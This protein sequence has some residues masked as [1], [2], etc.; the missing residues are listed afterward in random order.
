MAVFTAEFAG[1][2]GINPRLTRLIALENTFDEIT[3][4]GYLNRLTALGNPVLSTDFVFASYLDGYGTFNPSIDPSTGIITLIPT[5]AN[6]VI[7]ISPTDGMGSLQ[8]VS[9]DNAGDY[10]N[11]LTNAST[12]Q[13]T[14]W[15]LPDPG[16]ATANILLDKSSGTQTISA[17]NLAVSAG[18]FTASGAITSTA[19]AL[20]SGLAAGGFVGKTTL[21]PTTAAKGSVTWQAADNTGDTATIFTNAA[22]GQASTIS[23]PDPGA[24]AANFLLSKMTGTQH[25]TVGNLAIDAGALISGIATGGFVGKVQLFPTTASKGSLT[26]QATANSG[27]TATVF[28]T[29]ALGQATT[30]TVPDPV[31]AS[32]A[33]VVA[34]AALVSGNLVKASG[35]A[36]LVTDAGARI[37]SD[38][39]G[40]YGGGGTNNVFAA[41]GLTVAAKGAAVIRTSANSVSITKALPGTDTLDITFSA[42]PGAGTTVDYI[43]TTASQA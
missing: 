5:V 18:T 29:A 1:Q 31:A 17:G 40:A 16:S 38:T 32:G 24:S 2:T 34:P 27:D 33:I 20:V 30:Y 4:P 7:S 19:G 25:V 42:D 37:V 21:Y 22:M 12:G 23:V 15:T 35:T 36:G 39:T 3:T 26:W 11:V 8:L 10:A 6:N 43:Y 41:V 28:T 9:S 13:S 14:T